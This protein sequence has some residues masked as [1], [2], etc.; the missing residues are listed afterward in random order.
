MKKPIS[1]AVTVIV[2]VLVLVIVGLV[3]YVLTARREAGGPPRPP[4]V[5]MPTGANLQ[6]ATKALRAAESKT[7]QPAPKPAAP[8]TP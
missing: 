3:W 5:R 1:P 6:T 7:P 4:V 2:I 8:T